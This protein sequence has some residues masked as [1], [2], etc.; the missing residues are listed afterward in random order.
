[1]NGN[2]VQGVDKIKV[3]DLQPCDFCK[4]GKLSQGPHPSGVDNKGQHPLDLVVVDL[5]GP[6]R[7]QTLGGKLYDMVIIDTYT[8]CMFVILLRRKSDVEEA[9][10]RWI[11]QAEVQTSRKLNRLRSDN[12]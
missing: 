10:K 11:A 2:L 4:L 9:L 12:G 6:N 3:V 1:M 8:Q 5:A 7:P